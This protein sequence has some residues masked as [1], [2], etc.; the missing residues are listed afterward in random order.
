MPKPLPILHNASRR[1]SGW[2]AGKCNIVVLLVAHAL[3]RAA[4]AI[5]PTPGF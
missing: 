4:S 3:L 5:V 1:E 2:R